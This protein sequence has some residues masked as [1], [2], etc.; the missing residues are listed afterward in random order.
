MC[1]GCRITGV[2]IISDL[3][4]IQ[5]CQILRPATFALNHLHQHRFNILSSLQYSLTNAVLCITR[6]WIQFPFYGSR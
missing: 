5:T 2:R 4:S 1:I 3:Q 6:R